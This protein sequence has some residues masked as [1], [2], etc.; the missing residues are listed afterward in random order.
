[1]TAGRADGTNLDTDRIVRM[2]EAP[3][4]ETRIIRSLPV[5]RTDRMTRAALWPAGHP[6][7][8]RQL[9]RCQSRPSSMRA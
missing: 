1:M 2:A 3:V 6:P 8:G 9:S 4:V 5:G 7:S